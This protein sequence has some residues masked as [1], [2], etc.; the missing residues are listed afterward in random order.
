M[1]TTKPLPLTSLQKPTDNILRV[2]TPKGTR[3]LGIYLTDTAYDEYEWIS[4]HDESV[5]PDEMACV[6]SGGD[7]EGVED[8]TGEERT[9]YVDQKWNIWTWNSETFAWE[10]PTNCE[11]ANG[12]YRKAAGL[13]GGGF[14]ETVLADENAFRE[15]AGRLLQANPHLATSED[16]KAMCRSV[17]HDAEAI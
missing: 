7:Y 14:S 5:R 13:R 9:L 3:I 16:F 1:T 6:Q 15:A 12:L 17:L 11:Y 10:E 4:V 2:P 8:F